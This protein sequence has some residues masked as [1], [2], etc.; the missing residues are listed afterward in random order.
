MRF[1][2][3]SIHNKK[4]G[5]PISDTQGLVQLV[6]SKKVNQRELRRASRQLAKIPRIV[7]RLPR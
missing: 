5:P 2:K 3:D 4:M 7:T 6:E 1:K